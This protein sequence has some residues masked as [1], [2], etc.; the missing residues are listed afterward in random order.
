M[1]FFLTLLQQVLHFRQ[2]VGLI[3]IRSKHKMHTKYQEMEMNAGI[4]KSR[5][6]QIKYLNSDWN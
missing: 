6:I 4:F 2:F 1:R 3:A 5:K